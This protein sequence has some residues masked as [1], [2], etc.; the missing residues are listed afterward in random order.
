MS[1]IENSDE[2]YINNNYSDESDLHWIII[3]KFRRF[4]VPFIRTIVSL[5]TPSSCAVTFSRMR[6]LLFK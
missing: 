5:K 2:L 6:V 4:V 1:N 3:V